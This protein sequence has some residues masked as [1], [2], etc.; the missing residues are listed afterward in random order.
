MCVVFFFFLVDAGGRKPF[1]A[2]YWLIL[3]VGAAVFSEAILQVLSVL[4]PV[5]HERLV[6]FH[7]RLDFVLRETT[8]FVRSYF[9]FILLSHTHT[10]EEGGTSV[11]FNK[12]KNF[13]YSKTQHTRSFQKADR[14][15]EYVKRIW[16]LLL[17]PQETTPYWHENKTA[18]KPGALCSTTLTLV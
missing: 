1:C 13:E 4:I 2:A 11:R 8:L 9:W 17:F 16:F 18:L 10:R 5:A 15:F 7:K 6:A 12:S 14:S 3:L